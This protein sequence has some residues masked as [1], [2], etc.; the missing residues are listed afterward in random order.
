MLVTLDAEFGGKT[1]CRWFDSALA[2]TAGSIE[3]SSR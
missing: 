2:T 3:N 1:A